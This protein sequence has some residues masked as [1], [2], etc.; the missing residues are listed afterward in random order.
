MKTLKLV[1][2]FLMFG[3]LMVIG[4]SCG[5]DDDDDGNTGTPDGGPDSGT[6]SDTGDVPIDGI[7]LSNCTPDHKPADPHDWM[8]NFE[9]GSLKATNGYEEFIGFYAYNDFTP[10]A[11][12]VPPKNDNASEPATLDVPACS[13]AVMCTYNAEGKFTN[14]GAGL[15]MD[16]AEDPNDIVP[17]TDLPRKIPRDLTAYKGVAFYWL[18]RGGISAV[19]VGFGDINTSPDGDVCDDSDPSTQCYNDWAYSLTMT[20]ENVWVRQEI[21]FKDL[22]ISKAWG[23]QPESFA[24]DKVIGIKFQVAEA[25]DFDFCIDDLYLLPND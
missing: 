23:L 3:S 18:K 13:A 17:A 8:A 15:G 19:K 16:F 24:Q 20:Q 4:L 9:L 22:Q 10:G 25:A 5:E 14:W 12:Q 2:T 6:P 1:L 11:V 7:D 21:L